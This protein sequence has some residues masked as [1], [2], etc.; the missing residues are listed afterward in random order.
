MQYSN[1]IILHNS[2]KKKQ[3][4]VFFSGFNG[5]KSLIHLINY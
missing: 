2:E 1:K 4:K 3:S 5:K